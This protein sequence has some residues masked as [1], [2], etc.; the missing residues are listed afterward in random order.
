MQRHTRKRSRF[1]GI[2]M[3]MAIWGVAAALS[4]VSLWA[5]AAPDSARV[6]GSVQGPAIATQTGQASFYSTRYAG[7]TMADGTPM[8]LYANN[9]A[10]LTLP[11]GTRARVTDLETGRSAV[12]VIRDRGPYVNGRIIDLSPATAHQIGLT[13][14]QGLALVR[15]A[16]LSLPHDRIAM[17]RPA[18]GATWRRSSNQQSVT[19]DE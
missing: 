13:A 17:A 14:R 4:V 8:H 2:A 11:L 19:L 6:P 12:V 1:A 16:V 3:I 18:G 15:V 5:T 7:K 10:S 9:A